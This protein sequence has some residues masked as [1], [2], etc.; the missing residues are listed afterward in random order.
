MLK[1]VSNFTNLLD[2]KDVKYNFFPAENQGDRE[3]VKIEFGGE[4]GNDITFLFFFDPD[5]TTVSLCVV[6]FCKVA[7]EKLMD[8]YVTVNELN[9]KYRWIKLYINSDNKIIVETDAVI[10]ETTAGEVCFELLSRFFSITNEIY[11]QIM[12]VLWS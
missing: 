11:P 1:S 5:G 4:H 12:K 9:T 6:D 10:N 8:M 2:E 3:V 7:V